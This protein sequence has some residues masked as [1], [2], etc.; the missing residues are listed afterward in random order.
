VLLEFLSI[1]LTAVL[2]MPEFTYSFKE[3]C[4]IFTLL[5]KQ[6]LHSQ[7]PETLAEV[8]AYCSCP[9]SK[10]HFILSLP[11]PCCSQQK[12]NL[13]K[14]SNTKKGWYKYDI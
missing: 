1:A 12:L 8:H 7:Q 13:V 3:Q 4:K 5:Y 14:A 2:K 10:N 9:R 6:A 11:R